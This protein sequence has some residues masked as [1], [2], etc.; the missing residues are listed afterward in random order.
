MHRY[1]EDET[2]SAIIAGKR[3]R[4]GFIKAEGPL[5]VES[6]REIAAAKRLSQRERVIYG[7]GALYHYTTLTGFEGVI[8]SKGFWASDARFMNDAEE[9]RH[10]IELVASIL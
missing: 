1:E 9:V 4:L 3:Y 10:G 6:A 2:G 8:T 5:K 7:G